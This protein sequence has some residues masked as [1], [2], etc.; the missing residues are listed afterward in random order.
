DNQYWLPQLISEDMELFNPSKNP[1]YES[2][3]TRLFLAYKEGR[4]VGRI[5][6]ILN[7]AANN[8]YNAK[9]LRFGWFDTIED[10]DVSR[11]L[12]QAVEA[13]GIEKG[14]ETLTG[15]H[16]FTDLDQEGMLFEGYDQLPTISVYYNYPYYNDFVKKYGFKKEIDYFEFRAHIPQKGAIPPKLIRIGER[17][18]ERSRVKLL[19]FKNK[20]ELMARSEEMFILLDETFSDI[21]G[22]V[23]L[24]AKQM[25]YYAYKYMPFANKDLIQAVVDEEDRLIAFMIAMPSLSRAHQKAKGRLFPFGWFYILR[26]LKT[27][28]VLD[29]YLAGVKKEFQGK[30]V[31]L[32][33]TLEIAKEARKKGFDFSE[34]NPELET[35]KKIQAQW[36]HFDPTLHKKRRIYK[37]EIKM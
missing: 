3:E 24:T 12:F 11:T 26:A 20:K 5:A 37:K 1:A 36:K 32:L 14:M 8:K 31:V 15:P 7:H 35:N 23:P 34:S 16:G 19:K 30:G 22:T 28:K 9:N 18:R 13:W 6:A 33:M 27:Y 21:Y 17:L 10:Y 29:F 2:A 25:R 4:L